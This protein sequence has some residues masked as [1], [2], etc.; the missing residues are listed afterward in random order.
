MYIITCALICLAILSFTLVLDPFYKY[1]E[2]R[3]L[4]G[5][6]FLLCPILWNLPTLT[7]DSKFQINAFALFCTFAL[8]L[9][10][11]WGKGM[12]LKLIGLIV[13][14]GMSFFVSML[15]LT[16]FSIR[17]P[18]WLIS[19]ILGLLCMYISDGT[20]EAFIFGINAI[21]MF[22]LVIGIWDIIGSRGM[23]FDFASMTPYS[24]L[25]G[26]TTFLLKCFAGFLETIK[27]RYKKRA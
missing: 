16:F 21:W 27:F 24:A 5:F 8:A 9:T 26:I 7:F 11:I 18:Q 22:E 15:A 2:N 12:F 19:L 20:I 6:M 3:F 13:F 10:M 23:S 14:S 4:L 17:I 25:A 1:N